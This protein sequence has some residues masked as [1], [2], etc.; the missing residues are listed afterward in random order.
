MF[1]LNP[2]LLFGLAAVVIPPVVHF[3]ARRKYD[4]VPW[5]AMMFL[6]LSPK[7]RRRVLLERLLLMAVRMGT[8]GLLAVALAGPGVRSLFLARFEDRPAHTTVIL[9][10][11]SASMGHHHDGRAAVDAA[12]TWA[13]AF[14]DRCRPGDRV[15]L[16]AVRSEAVPL[17]GA[18]AD[19]EAV[20]TALE[21]L[22]EP[23]GSA[24]WP[25]AVEAAAKVLEDAG[26][27]E[28]LVLSD[29]QRV[30]WADAD[31]V[32]RWDLLARKHA[33]GRPLPRVWAVNVVPDRPADGPNAGLG[34][35][36]ASR[37]VASAGTEVRFTGTIR[38]TGPPGPLPRVRLEIDGRPAGDVAATAGPVPAETP[39]AFARRFGPGSHL[40]TL[41]LDPDVLPADDRQDFALDVL[42]AV[43]VLIVDGGRPDARSLRSD[44]LRAALA[45]ARDPSP[46]FAVRT[47][48]AD[49]LGSAVL[50]QEVAG[51][52][53]PPQVLVL[54]D[55][56]GLTAE[57]DRVVERFL[58]D[59][60][61][62]LVLF[63]DR[64]V[65][66]AWREGKAWLPA[67][68]GELGGTDADSLKVPRPEAAEL[69]HPVS[70]V[71]RNRLLTGA[72]FPRYWK[73]RPDAG[74]P[75]LVSCALSTGDPLFVERPTGGGRVIVSAVP[76]D[77]TWGAN[78][79][80]LLGFVP[81]AH[82]LAY[83]L[84]GTAD[85]PA[86]LS[87]GEPLVVR[88]REGEPTGAVTVQPPDAPPAAVS[89]RGGTAVFAATRDPGV[90]R[91]TTAGGRVR[92]FVVRP[93][94]R[95]FDLTPADEADR[96][97][98]TQAVGS[99]AHVGTVDG[100]QAR[101][102]RGPVER[103]LTGLLLAVVLALLAAEVWYTRWLAGGG[104]APLRVAATRGSE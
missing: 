79:V 93:D 47:V 61:G 44:F 87:A 24:D 1:F 99:V 9:V 45:P 23:R 35:V 50:A 29:G 3:F 103:D 67:R 75:P 2:L 69:D 30:G 13:A 73:L 65:P 12:K 92:Y 64:C 32:A 22:P 42:P 98:V 37:P 81:L 88:L 21:L 39:F 28:L 6:R 104:R 101:R 58:G 33:A 20:R 10:D 74:T 43:P 7:S 46:A 63:G 41:K 77:N 82:E 27:G 5:A 54:A 100:L 34:P 55:L 102:G 83:R 84:A 16:F 4:E 96:R 60:G 66:A 68:P 18:A 70:G 80:G 59:G 49:Q 26:G 17:V 14:L 53:V 15:A 72:V 71:F 90:Y 19:P 62:V 25:A 76:L 95:E 31:A 56:V 36:A 91:A 97:R 78:L 8:L 38:R 48:H 11:A 52:G 89:V 85:T 40:V 57:Q 94:P 51:S 86:N